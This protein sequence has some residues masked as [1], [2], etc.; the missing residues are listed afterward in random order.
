M[1][2][3]LVWVELAPPVFWLDPAAMV[4]VLLAGRST[5]T[6]GISPKVGCSEPLV[7]V[8]R[9]WVGVRS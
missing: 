3:P 9:V 1:A 5:W 2:P 8:Q 6:S 7:M 4:G